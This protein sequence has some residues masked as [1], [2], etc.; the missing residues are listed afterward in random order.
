[1]AKIIFLC[2]GLSIII[3]SNAMAVKAKY[4]FCDSSISSAPGEEDSIDNNKDIK[5]NN[6]APFHIPNGVYQANKKFFRSLGHDCLG[7]STLEVVS[8]G[9]KFLM[10]T[11][12]KDECDGGNTFGIIVSEENNREVAQVNDG[13]IE[14][15][16]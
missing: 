1:M 14:C 10:Y 2:L 12:N 3:W 15:K 4:S 11:T 13:L 7:L 9:E 16:P 6:K 8:T 5:L